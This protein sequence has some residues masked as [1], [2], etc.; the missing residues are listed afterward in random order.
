[1]T[2]AEANLQ[3][4]LTNDAIAVKKVTNFILENRRI[5]IHV[6]MYGTNLLMAVYGKLFILI[7]KV[8]VFGFPVC[9]NKHNTIYAIAAVKT[10][11]CSY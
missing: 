5:T 1:M 7:S 11:Q 2:S 4:S 10:R 3:P 6:F 8:S 9:K